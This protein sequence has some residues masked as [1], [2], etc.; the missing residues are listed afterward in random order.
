MRPTAQITTLT[1]ATPDIIQ[2]DLKDMRSGITHEFSLDIDAPHARDLKVGSQVSYHLAATTGEPVIEGVVQASL[3]QMTLVHPET[4][5][6]RHVKL[7]FSWTTM[8]FAPLGGIPLLARK[9]R[10]PYAIIAGMTAFHYLAVFK[11]TPIPGAAMPYVILGMPMSESML[12]GLNMGLLMAEAGLSVFFGAHANRW[13]AR[14]L[15]RQG[16]RLPQSASEAEISFFHAH[17]GKSARSGGY[18]LNLAAPDIPQPAKAAYASA[19]I[20]RRKLRSV[21]GAKAVEPGKAPERL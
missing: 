9:L 21:F 17:V 13:H 11:A 18:G 19:S 4:G 10:L 2:G 20:S 15:L 6:K 1:Q 3:T 8:A 12:S 5:R 14:A 7:G 16:Y